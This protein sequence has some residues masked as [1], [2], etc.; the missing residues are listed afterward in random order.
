MRVKFPCSLRDAMPQKPRFV[1][2]LRQIDLPAA[3]PSAVDAR[4]DD[5]QGRRTGPPRS[6]LLFRIVGRQR[7]R[8]SARDQIVFA[9]VQFGSRRGRRRRH[10]VHLTWTTTRD[11]ARK[12]ARRSCGTD[13]RIRIRCIQSAIRRS[14]DRPA[15]A[16]SRLL[17]F[18]SSNAATLRLSRASAVDRRRDTVRTAIE[19]AHAQRCSS[20]A[21][22]SDTVGCDMRKLA[23]RLGHAAGFR[24]RWR[25]CRGR[26]PAIAGRGGFPIPL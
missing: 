26:A 7:Q 15:N 18:S 24:P 9:I 13:G 4:H 22:T 16:M 8:R 21:I 1:D 19:Q 3:S 2:Q 11:T 20:S 25:G 14:S 23:R 5:Q 17:C 6:S 12:S 10:K